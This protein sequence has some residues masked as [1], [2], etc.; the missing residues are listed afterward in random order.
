MNERK[1]IA[2]CRELGQITGEEQIWQEEVKEKLETIINNF[3][4]TGYLE[5]T[6]IFFEKDKKPKKIKR[7]LY[8]KIDK[9]Y[10]W[11][12]TGRFRKRPKNVGGNI[13]EVL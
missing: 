6:Q 8:P 9:L 3:L 4:K 12:A 2:I 7:K 5:Y 10:L 11:K 13:K 1:F